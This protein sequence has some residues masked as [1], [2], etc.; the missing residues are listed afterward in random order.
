MTDIIG[1]ILIIVCL[2]AEIKVMIGK[3][4]LLRIH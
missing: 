1:I 3:R 4:K 2:K